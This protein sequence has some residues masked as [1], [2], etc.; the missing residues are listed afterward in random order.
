MWVN[1]MASRHELPM[2]VYQFTK[3]NRDGGDKLALSVPLFSPELPKHCLSVE[4]Y[5]R[6]DRCR[7]KLTA[8]TPVKYGYNSLDKTCIFATSDLSLNDTCKWTNG[9]SNPTTA[10]GYPINFPHSIILPVLQVTDN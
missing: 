1:D 2:M 7:R 8:M 4:H 9:N 5:I 3:L 10:R 6:I